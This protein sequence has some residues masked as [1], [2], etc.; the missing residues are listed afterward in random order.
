MISKHLTQILFFIS[1]YSTNTFSQYCIPVSTFGSS[2]SDQVSSVVIDGSNYAGSSNSYDSLYTSFGC[3]IKMMTNFTHKIFIGTTGVGSTYALFFDFN[4]D[5]DFIDI[6]EKIGEAVDPG[7]PDMLYF[8]VTIP[9]S[10][11]GNIRG[12]IR[13]AESGVTN[14][15]P[16]SSYNYGTTLDFW[17]QINSLSNY[18]TVGYCFPEHACNNYPASISNIYFIDRNIASLSSFSYFDHSNAS[19]N[20]NGNYSVTINLQGEYYLW[21]DYNRDGQFTNVNEYLGVQYSLPN[22]QGGTNPASFNFNIPS[23]LKQGPFMFRLRYFPLFTINTSPPSP[24][25]ANSYYNDIDVLYTGNNYCDSLHSQLCNSNTIQSV[26]I[27]GTNFANLNNGCGNLNGNSYTIFDPSANTTATV[28]NGQP[29]K[30]NVQTDSLSNVALWLDFNNDL[31]FDIDE[32]TCISTFTNSPGTLIPSNLKNG[33][34]I[35]LRIRSSSITEPIGP[36]DA[37]KLLNSG[38]TEDY[39]LTVATNLAGVTFKLDMTPAIN[40]AIFN[41]AGGDN[42]EMVRYLPNNNYQFIALT[43]DIGNIFRSTINTFHNG[44]NIYYKFRINHNWSTF[45]VASKNYVVS[46]GDTVFN[47][48]DASTLTITDITYKVP[49][50]FRVDMSHEQIS[51]FGVRMIGNFNQWD[52]DSTSMTPIGNGIYEA[53]VL[54]DTVSNISYQFVNGNLIADHENISCDCGTYDSNKGNLR[55]L[56]IVEEADTIPIVCYGSCVPCFLPTAQ[57]TNQSAIIACS[58]SQIFLPFTTSPGFQ[59]GN[60]FSAELSD[61]TGSFNNPTSLGNI[62]STQNDSILASFPNFFLGTGNG[63]TIRLVSSSPYLILDS[64]SIFANNSP[65][66]SLGPDTTICEGDSIELFLIN[67]SQSNLASINW[68]N[69]LHQNQTT[70]VTTPFVNTIYS[71]IVVDTLGCTSFDDK[72]ILL[73][74]VPSPPQ[75]S[76]NQGYLICSTPAQNYSWYLNGVSILQNDNDSLS[77]LSTGLYKLCISNQFGCTSCTNY[78]YTG[79]DESYESQVS[80]SPTPFNNK[81]NI[82]LKNE[83]ISTTKIDFYNVH[84][85]LVFTKIVDNSLLEISTSNWTDGIYFFIATSNEKILIRKKLLKIRTAFE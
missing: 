80:V 72:I 15:S 42:V 82:A 78:N 79:I 13:C 53:T 27:S 59:P 46:N 66:V 85:V 63:Y 39:L 3:E 30:I 32:Y 41:I 68:S 29:I 31:V 9:A 36:G 55:F 2:N 10:T 21:A 47:I 51:P 43:Y 38:E 49:V 26:S 71:V 83:N 75:L 6:D 1:L 25:D 22:S 23:N 84:G 12:R 17:T 45:E 65:I 24:C 7:N 18:P 61:N 19:I 34:L 48:W 70:Q 69:G 64:I 81:L 16:C 56:D 11:S 74:S 4:S 44:D 5:G 8:N 33:D 77:I 57:F 76:F 73:S 40:Q 54:L 60:N 20:A 52:L 58:S 50:T 37:C 62:N 14:L 35:P 67:S 28:E